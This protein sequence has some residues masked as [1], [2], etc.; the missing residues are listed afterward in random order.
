MLLLHARSTG[1]LKPRCHRQ[2][3]LRAIIVERPLSI[4]GIVCSLIESSQ[5]APQDVS[6]EQAK[7]AAADGGSQ[8]DVGNKLGPRTTSLRSH[9][10]SASTARDA[11]QWIKARSPAPTA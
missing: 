10:K 6:G 3:R 1:S 11:P 9:K 8:H 2:R 7:I 4:G 5:S